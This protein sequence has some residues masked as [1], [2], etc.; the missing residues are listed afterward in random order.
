MTR[1]TKVMMAATAL[2][3]MTGVAFAQVGGNEAVVDQLGNNNASTVYQDQ[4]ATN[5]SFNRQNGNRNESV[6]DQDGTNNAVGTDTDFAY[7]EGNRN[8]LTINQRG[9][10]FDGRNRVGA[11]LVDGGAGAGFEQL[12]NRNEASINQSANR[13]II[14]EI[15]QDSRNGDGSVRNQL[16]IDQTATNY[17]YNV[18]NRLRQTRTGSGSANTAD[19][20]Q[21]GLV[22]GLNR[23]D[24]VVQEGQG[25]SAVLSQTGEQNRVS[26]T[27][28]LGDGN[29]LSLNVSGDSNGST[30]ATFNGNHQALATFSGGA[31]GA[32]GLGQGTFRQIGNNNDAF[33]SIVGDENGAAVLQQGNLNLI[34][35]NLFG[36]NNGFAVAQFGNENEADIDVNGNFNEVGIRQISEGNLATV[37]VN[38]SN[39]SASITQNGTNNTAFV[40]Q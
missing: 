26:E 25:N 32:I 3:M 20:D 17:G 39:N 5:S 13:N 7:Q 30:V 16:S 33:V 40:Q 12:G 15:L 8:V 24:N 1:F 4:G 2:S 6:I 27:L 18:V 34:S 22:N 31:A 19:I 9:F 29:T 14:G 35:A 37:L 28:Q 10:S 11:G 38:S 36:N 21:V 23:V